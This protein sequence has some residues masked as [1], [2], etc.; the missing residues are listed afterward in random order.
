[1]KRKAPEVLSSNSDVLLNGVASIATQHHRT[2][3][4]DQ[5]TSEED[6][7]NIDNSIDSD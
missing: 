6:D 3:N 2:I 1:M 5:G 4:T 7:E